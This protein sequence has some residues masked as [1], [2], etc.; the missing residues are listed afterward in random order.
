MGKLRK[1]LEFE[2]KAR[3]EQRAAMPT[4][5]TVQDDAIRKATTEQQATLPRKSS[6][7]DVTERSFNRTERIEQPPK[8]PTNTQEVCSHVSKC[9]KERRLKY[10]QATRPKSSGGE[11]KSNQS[12]PS[13]P[14]TR[15]RARS[16]GMTSPFV[17][18]DIPMQDLGIVSQ[19]LPELTKARNDFALDIQHDPQ[20]CVIC[21]GIMKHGVDH[22]HRGTP[23][24]S[25]K[26]PK[27]KSAS[28]RLAETK[29]HEDEPTIRP[30]QP[31]AL[32]LATV[33]KSLTDEH[34][35]L[36]IQHT[37]IKSLY[38]RHDPAI[39]K[40]KRK[41]LFAKMVSLLN[42]M[43]VK[44]DQIYSL[45]DVLEDYKHDGHVEFQD[46]EIED[47]LQ[48]IGIDLVELGLRGGE[49]PTQT[50]TQ[51]SSQRQPWD[52]E[53]NETGTQDLPWEG[54]DNTTGT[55]KSGQTGTRRRS[56]AT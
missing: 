33:L 20:G 31:P 8:E 1:T 27:P 18:P 40:T 55:S 50:Q 19:P 25:I 2:R 14:V 13:A 53:S 15:R 46:Q 4:R 29:Q 51:K 36:L 35:H 45:H 37:H 41:D 52:L 24:E 32:A 39:M 10:L 28:E 21:K 54:L 44:A 12:K 11:Q 23:K 5:S 16:L 38:F 22:D 6:M 34:A 43:E 47:T 42:A 17:I 30:S 7:K 26:I 48:S 56:W 9:G 49:A 3:K